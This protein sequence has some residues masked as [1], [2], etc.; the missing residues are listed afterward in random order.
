MLSKAFENNSSV[1]I[2]LSEI[3]LNKIGQWGRFLGRLLRPLLKNV[4]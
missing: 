1:N 3:Q 4:L 2:K